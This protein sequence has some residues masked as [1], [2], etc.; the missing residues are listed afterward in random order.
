MSLLEHGL[1]FNDHGYI[2]KPEIL[3]AHEVRQ[4]MLVLIE[5]NVFQLYKKWQRLPRKWRDEWARMEEAEKY[6]DDG[7]QFVKDIGSIGT[8][9]TK[10]STKCESCRTAKKLAYQN[11]M[12]IDGD[13]SSKVDGVDSDAGEIT[14]GLP[15][16][17]KKH[18]KM[19]KG[20]RNRD[21][22][23]PR[24]PP[25]NSKTIML[26]HL[27]FVPLPSNANFDEY[28][29]GP[30]LE[31]MIDYPAHL[32][33][34]PLNPYAKPT[35]RGPW[36]T[37]KDYGY[38][39]E[40]SFALMFNNADPILVADHVLPVGE[41]SASLAHLQ[42]ITGDYDISRKGEKKTVHV[43]DVGV[44][45]MEEMLIAAGGSG[46]EES[47]DVFV[48]GRDSCNDYIRID[49]EKDKIH[50]DADDVVTVV[51]VDSMIWVTH[52]LR[53][54]QALKIFVLPRIAKR[55]PIWR[56]NHVYAEIL[57]P[58]SDEDRAKGG[59]EEWLSKAFPLTAIPHTHFAMLGDGAGS[60]N[61]YVFFPRMIHR[62][63]A[64]GYRVNNIPIEIQSVWFDEIVLPAIITCTLPGGFE[65]V[66]FTLDEWRWKASINERFE[67]VRSTPLRAAALD[68]MQ[69]C[70]R[71][72]INNNPDELDMFG[73][74]FF[75]CDF[76]GA[77]GVTTSDD[78]YK[79][80][81]NEYPAM[82]W[83]YAM[84]RK[85]GQ[86]F[87]DVGIS[88]HAVTYDNIPLVGLWRLDAVDASYEAAGM[89]KG[90][91]HHTN[92]LAAYGGRQ[93]E[94]EAIRMRSVQL[95]FRSTYNLVFEAIRRPGADTYFCDD[96]EAYDVSP[97]F[98]ECFVRYEKIFKGSRRKSFGVRE[99]IRG[100]GPAMKIV[101]KKALERVRYQ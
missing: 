21:L 63:S 53:F 100:S 98:Q 62:D 83:D 39:L 96:S 32:D 89:N 75:V 78:P 11:S 50:V 46:S 57:M 16:H 22:L 19:M 58:R 3:C 48:R 41:R 6:L 76:R 93:A 94:A 37:F 27:G 65:Y 44:M 36:E 30:T 51:D 90:V 28:Y 74:F 85:N 18:K 33:N 88:F 72:I 26:P 42:K 95:N 79:T 4:R 92:T 10:A 29:L 49:L 91:T 81:L 68:D 2:L 101:L 12:D 97:S 70:M 31:D 52:E 55:A 60:I 13:S 15:D 14:I 43:D 47:F 61:V 24:R 7:E 67:K 23:A 45:G 66:Q 73:S 5:N 1:V 25:A 64:R 77:K 17:L 80:L 84:D 20:A 34:F 54:K 35:V 38:R 40:P 87:L 9:L 99:E 59:R 71:Q 86:L 56:H 8:T 69:Y 82:D